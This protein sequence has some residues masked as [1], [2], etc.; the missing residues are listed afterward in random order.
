MEWNSLKIIIS[1][2]PLG[3][4]TFLLFVSFLF[5]GMGISAFPNPVWITKQFGISELTA[6]GK[7]EVRAV[8]GGFGLCMSLALILAYCI[9]E[10][11]NGVC[12]TVALALFGMSLGRMVSAAMDRSIAKLPAFYGAIELIASIILVFS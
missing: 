9:P 12:I 6:S 4:D 1:S 5:A 2:H 11:R 7:N 8:Y 10:I 3:S